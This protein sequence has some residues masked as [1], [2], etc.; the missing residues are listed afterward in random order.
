MK[1]DEV[2]EIRD[3]VLS[4]N[5][6]AESDEVIEKVRE[7]RERHKNMPGQ[8]TPEEQEEL[9]GMVGAILGE[10]GARS[11]PVRQGVPVYEMPEY[12]QEALA[13][14]LSNLAKQNEEEVR[15]ALERF[16]KARQVINDH[17]HVDGMEYTRERPD[18]DTYFLSMLPGIGA[19]ATCNRGYSGCLIV[20]DNRILMSGYVGSPPGMEHCDDVGHEYEWRLDYDPGQ[21]ADLAILQENLHRHCVRT[22]H[23][24]ANAI[25]WCARKGVSVE[26]AT[27][28]CKMTPCRRCAEAIVQVGIARVVVENLYHAGE[29]SQVILARGGV[30]F[31][32]IDSK[33]ADYTP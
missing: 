33:N 28:Y 15:A 11:A 17:V 26:G 13:Q 1:K 19:R 23:A 7:I 6:G 8:Q 10:E 30:D 32:V 12:Q 18:W 25:Y 29:E 9:R 5:E 24:E 16:N 4:F 22:I 27:L 2:L 31:K 21:F 20:S 3:A 14:E